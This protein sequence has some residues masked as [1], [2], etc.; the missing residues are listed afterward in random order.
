MALFWHRSY[1]DHHKEK[2]GSDEEEEKRLTWR[3]RQGHKSEGPNSHPSRG[4]LFGPSRIVQFPMWSAGAE[5]FTALCPEPSY[6]NFGL[7]R[8][9]Q[10]GRQRVVRQVYLYRPID[11]PRRKPGFSFL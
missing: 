11:Q 9:Y 6:R 1:S 10:R 7:S 3:R 5:R 4:K 8:H 2:R